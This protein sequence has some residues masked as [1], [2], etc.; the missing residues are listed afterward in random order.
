MNQHWKQI[1]NTYNSKKGT[2]RG[3]HFQRDPFSE[4]KLV[5]C[6]SGSIWDVIIDIRK[7]SITFGKYFG[8]EL[9]TKNRSMMYVPTGFAHGFVTLSD[10]SEVI[11]LVSEAYNK[12]YEAG[13]IWND[14]D[15]G[16]KWPI[17]PRIMSEKD[18]NASKLKDILI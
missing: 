9:N 2:L 1:N 8:Q 6:I 12:S 15:L 17:E 7:D 16:I 10:E 4:I 3:L 11:Y 18:S 5:R 13:I 14:P